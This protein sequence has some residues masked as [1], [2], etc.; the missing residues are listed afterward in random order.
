MSRSSTTTRRPRA[1]PGRAL[2]PVHTGEILRE[3]LMAPLGL[4][5]N[6][7]AR[8]LHVPVNRVSE[9]VNGHR[10]ITA[11]TALRLARYFRSSPE[12]WLNLQST[13]DLQCAARERATTIA[14]EVRPRSAA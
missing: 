4:S 2:P 6:R 11:D 14:R 8:E 1:R 7:L 9:I 12:F 10:G 3:D 5:I 13:Y